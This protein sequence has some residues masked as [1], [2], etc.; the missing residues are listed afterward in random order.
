ME[1]PDLPAFS[2]VDAIKAIQSGSAHGSSI[3][4]IGG[5]LMLLTFVLRVA[6]LR[7]DWK[8]VDD[9]RVKALL[10][11]AP[12]FVTL[13]GVAGFGLVSGQAQPELIA[14]LLNTLLAGVSS[15]G[16]WEMLGKP[17]VARLPEKGKE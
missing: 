12:T 10:R 3:L 6:I 11:L 14:A 9:P 17:V 2:I 13:I 1:T 16:L 5:V 8:H 7:Q 4:L 15:V